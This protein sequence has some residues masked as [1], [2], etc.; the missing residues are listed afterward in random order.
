MVLAVIVAWD[1]TALAGC[2]GEAPIIEPVPDQEVAVGDELVLVLHAASRDGPA[3]TAFSVDTDAPHVDERTDLLR[4]PDG[5]A[6]FR[7]RP[8]AQ[9]VGRWLFDFRARDSGGTALEEVVVTVRRAR[10]GAGPIFRRPLGAGTALDLT[11]A[12][13]ADLEVE[14][15]DPDSASL[16]ITQAPPIIAGSALERL[17]PGQARWRWCPTSA[18]A[19]ARDRY[20]LSL[21][22]DDGRGPPTLLH[23][24]IVLVSRDQGGPDAGADDACHPADRGRDPDADPPGGPTSSIVAG[25]TAASAPAPPVW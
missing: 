6:V 21:S 11:R 2:A 20:L 13:C 23:F 16:R 5:S 19:T 10:P 12:E 7:F 22:A 1:V 25:R 24:Q 14:V 9:D 8:S 18:Q 4:R 17:G 15:S 3:R